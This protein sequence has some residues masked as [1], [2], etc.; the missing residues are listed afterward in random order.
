[1]T[2]VAAWFGDDGLAWLGALGEDMLVTLD[3]EP[4]PGALGS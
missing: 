1:M 3:Q 2:D 4:D